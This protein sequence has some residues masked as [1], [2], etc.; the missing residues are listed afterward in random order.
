M[1]SG[2]YAYRTVCT[3]HSRAWDPPSHVIGTHQILSKTDSEVMGV[4]NYL[5]LNPKWEP[6]IFIVIIIFK[7]YFGIRESY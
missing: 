3:H 2:T 4:D 6:I 5:W 1:D 7:K